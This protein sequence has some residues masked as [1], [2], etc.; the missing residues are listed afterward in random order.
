LGWRRRGDLLDDLRV[1]GKTLI[2]SPQ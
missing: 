1:F 2:K